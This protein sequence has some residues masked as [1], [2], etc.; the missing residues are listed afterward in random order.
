MNTQP[1]RWMSEEDTKRFLEKLKGDVRERRFEGVGSQRA[2]LV[3]QAFQSSRN[4]RVPTS[5]L[6]LGEL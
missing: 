5:E 4:S 2:P 1:I 6:S 3:P